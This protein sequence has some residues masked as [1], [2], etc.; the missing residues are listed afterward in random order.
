MNKIPVLMYHSIQGR[1]DAGSV[2]DYEIKEEDFENQMRFL[3]ENGYS[4]LLFNDFIMSKKIPSK[5]VVITFDD[6]HL[7]NYTIAFPMLLKFGFRAEFFITPKQITNTNRMKVHHLRE[8]IEK[9]MAIGSHGLTHAYLDDLDDMEAK[10]ELQQSK[11]NLSNMLGRSVDSFSAPGGRFRMK[12]VQYAI[13]YGYHV[14]CTSRPGLIGPQT[15]LLKV[16]RMPVCQGNVLDFKKIVT[17]DGF[18]YFKKRIIAYLLNVFKKIL[19]NRR[20]ENVRSFILQG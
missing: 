16:P 5:G 9:G 1:D 2:C 12:H 11:E 10:K 13:N 19:G 20:Y 18:F 6:G 7:S 4:S 14:F 15:S 17:G 8:M 3:V